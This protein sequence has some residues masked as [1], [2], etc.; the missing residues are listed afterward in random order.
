MENLVAG[1]L[2]IEVYPE[3]NPIR[4]AWIG[5]CNQRDPSFFLRPFFRRLIGEAAARGADMEMQFEKL[6]Y[7]N[8]STITAVIGILEEL[9]AS[10]VKLVITYNHALRAQRLSFEALRIFE[11]DDGMFRLVTK[12]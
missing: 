5:K 1:D 2:T 12:R 6:E 4:V 9:R 3:A 10:K 8:S 7:F 11:H